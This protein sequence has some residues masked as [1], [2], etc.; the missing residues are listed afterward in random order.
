M[1]PECVGVTKLV[2]L[3]AIVVDTVVV[4]DRVFVRAAVAVPQELSVVDLELLVD[5][6]YVAEEVDVFVDE[7][8]RVSA[9]DSVP[10]EDVE[11]E[12]VE[13]IVGGGSRVTE[14]VAL[15]VTE[16]RRETLPQ[17]DAVAVQDCFAV[18]DSVGVVVYVAAGFRVRLPVRE[19]GGV[20]VSALQRVGEGELDG[21]FEWG[22]LRVGLALVFRER[23]SLGENVP[24]FEDVIVRVAVPEAVGVLEIGPLRVPVEDTVDVFD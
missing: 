8:E 4:A 17:A 19:I 21:V 9:V 15:S 11:A 12:P 14:T 24:V 18:A 1:L 7:G 3:F 23:E 5:A 22:G 20:N 13:D 16:G 6:V 10:L 2:L